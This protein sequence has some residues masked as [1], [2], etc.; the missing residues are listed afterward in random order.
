ML[1]G[2]AFGG[3]IGGWNAKEIAYSLLSP[4]IGTPFDDQQ[5]KESIRKS[6]FIKML[7]RQ[8]QLEMP[9]KS[10]PNIH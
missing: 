4:R 9:L 3:V 7:P 6:K 5:E 2:D 8:S 1:I 10:L